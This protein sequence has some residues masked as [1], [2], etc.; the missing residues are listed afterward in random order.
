[1]KGR[2]PLP[3]SRPFSCATTFATEAFDRPD[4]LRTTHE[5][6]VKLPNRLPKRPIDCRTLHIVAL[7]L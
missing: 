1:L 4:G 7:T 6:P 2:L 3:G 5:V